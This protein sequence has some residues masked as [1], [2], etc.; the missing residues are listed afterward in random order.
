PPVRRGSSGKR[1]CGCSWQSRRWRKLRSE[2]MPGTFTIRREQTEAYRRCMLEDFENRAVQHLRQ[3]L[4]E[5][6]VP[7]SD[8]A[9]RQRVRTCVPRARA[10]GLATERQIMGFVNPSYLL[11]EWFDRDPALS[12]TR[13]VLN[14]TRL[15]AD[16]RAELLEWTAWQ[17]HAVGRGE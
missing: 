4:S 15:N 12:W 5:L 14:S 16:D 11:G 9:L 7:F 10:H 6:M 8:E 13:D 2:T 3:Y 1:R 17:I